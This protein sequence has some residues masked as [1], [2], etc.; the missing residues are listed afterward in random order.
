[1][2]ITEQFLKIILVDPDLISKADFEQAKKEAKKRNESLENILMEI[3]D[4][5]SDTGHGENPWPLEPQFKSA[6]RGNQEVRG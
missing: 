4:L 6:H 1:M 3:K 5:R 2:K